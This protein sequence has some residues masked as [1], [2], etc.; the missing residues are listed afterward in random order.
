MTN[1]EGQIPGHLSVLGV[2]Q[3]VP[4]HESHPAKYPLAVV[5]EAHAEDPRQPL[6]LGVL[7]G[8][9]DQLA[10]QTAAPMRDPGAEDEDVQQFVRLQTATILIR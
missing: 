6:R 2:L 3:T 9:L 1:L 4:L 10:G 7:Q 8:S 5:A